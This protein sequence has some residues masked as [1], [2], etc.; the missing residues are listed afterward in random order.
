MSYQS[1]YNFQ[2][3]VLENNFKKEDLIK[4]FIENPPKSLSNQDFKGFLEA[5]RKF[6]NTCFEAEESV[7]DIC[8]T[9]GDGLSTFNISTC[10]SFVLSAGGVKIAKHGNRSA[11]S[12]SGSADILELAG[13]KID[14]EPEKAEEVF[15]KLGLVFLFAPVYH[16]AFRFA[17]P[18]RKDFGKKTYFNFLG[19]V[20][21][22]AKVK[23][24]LIGISDKTIMKNLGKALI[25]SG[26]KKIILVSGENGM[27]EVNSCGKTY[28]LEIKN[29]NDEVDYKNYEIIPEDF[30]LNRCK[31]EDL[32]IFSPENSLEIMKNV[33]QGAGTE[34]QNTAVILNSA[35]AFYLSGKVDSIVSG[36]EITKNI[37]KSKKGYIELEKMIKETQND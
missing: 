18:A 19:P 33:L 21:N 26:S 29:L 11:S 3:Q 31:E 15:N 34:A 30:G 4:F 7:I 10:S 32:N 8:G 13:I 6:Q 37:L 2:K 14:L 1:S 36:V 9:G 23:R 24:Q 22:P 12:K 17:A 35:M 16:P 25:N 20:L 27:D 5:S 28:V